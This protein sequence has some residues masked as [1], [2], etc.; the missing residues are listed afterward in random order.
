MSPRLMRIKNLSKLRLEL[1]IMQVLR[2]GETSP[3]AIVLIF[4]LSGVSFTKCA[5]SS[6]PS[7]AVL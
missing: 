2:F 1:L 7:R 6:L 4:G 3:T 5:L